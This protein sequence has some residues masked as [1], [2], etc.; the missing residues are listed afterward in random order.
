MNCYINYDDALAQIKSAGLIPDEPL[1]LARSGGRSRRCMVNG[2]DNEK[3]GWYILHEW[4]SRHGERFLTGSY[5]IYQ[6]DDPGT[7]KIELTKKCEAC[8]HEMPLREKKCPRC[9]ATAFKK[10]ELD[11]E[12]LKAIKA[13]QAED[14]KRAEAERE[15]EITRAAQWASAVWRA[16]IAAKPEDH[17]YIGRKHL[18]GTH[19]ARIFAST[20]GLQLV[21]AVKEDF[22]HLAGFIGALVIPMCDE[23]GSVF[24][25]QFI[26]SRTIHGDRI[27]RTERD[28]EY[29]PQGLSKDAH[30]FMIGAPGAVILQ[31]EGF[32]TAASLHEASGHAVAVAFDAGNMPKVAKILRKQYRR[33]ALL[34]CADDDWLQK[35]AECKGLAPVSEELCPHCGK[36][37]RKGNAGVS[38]A[39]EAAMLADGAWVKPVF[40]AARPVDRKGPTDFND[41]AGL[42]GLQ[43]VRAQ[44]E[45]KFT[46]MGVSAPAPASSRSA[47]AFSQGLGVAAR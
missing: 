38:R 46:E 37:H 42:E 2:G 7:L 5:G 21:G 22:E 10:R 35:C 1:D 45:S 43:V 13:R 30:Y 14:K 3:R 18:S 4:V 47:G 33:A 25:L 16:S 31:A 40:A 34:C 12:E 29:W 39:A 15:S 41:L 17:D 28:K 11:P 19:G 44:I 23:N 6:G 20:E 9:S 27:R 26:L 8:G 32:A 24:G 36:P